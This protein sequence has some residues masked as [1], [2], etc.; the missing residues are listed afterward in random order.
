MT[1]GTISVDVRPVSGSAS[2]IVIRG[3]VTPASETALTE[4]Y[5][6]AIS[7]GARSIVLDFSVL[8]YMNSGGIGLLA[9]MTPAATV[10]T[11][12][13]CWNPRRRSS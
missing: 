4:A 3:D 13:A 5:T 6:R 12:S 7:E 2:F 8:D 11:L 9:P 1:S 10:S